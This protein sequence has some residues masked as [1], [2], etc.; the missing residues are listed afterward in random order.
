VNFK[1]ILINEKSEGFFITSFGLLKD[2]V[3]VP[4]PSAFAEYVAV[5]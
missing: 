2:K 1:G 5:R 4:K 3:P